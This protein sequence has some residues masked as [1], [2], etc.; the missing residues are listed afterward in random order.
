M[1][2]KANKVKKL[3]NYMD[4]FELKEQTLGFVASL[5]KYSIRPTI[6]I[7]FAAFRNELYN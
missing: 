6:N 1:V 3:V 5:K 4:Y 7:N 2:S